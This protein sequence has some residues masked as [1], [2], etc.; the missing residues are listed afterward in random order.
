MTT[1]IGRWRT[2]RDSPE[3]N[4][5]YVVAHRGNMFGNAYFLDGRWVQH[6]GFGPTHWLDGGYEELGNTNEKQRMFEQL[7]YEPETKY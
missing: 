2:F 3:R 4:G 7:G 5:R 6:P 1:F